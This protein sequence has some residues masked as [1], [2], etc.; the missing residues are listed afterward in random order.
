MLKKIL[1]G[2]LIG[3]GALTASASEI[4]INK[5]LD[6]LADN[7][8]FEARGEGIAGWEMV[9]RVTLNRVASSQFPDTISKVVHQ[10]KG[11][12]CQF[13]WYCDKNVQARIQKA[14]K[15]KIWKDI[16][17][18]VEGEYYEGSNDGKKGD[19]LFYHHKRLSQKKLGL[20][21]KVNHYATVGQHKFY[22]LESEGT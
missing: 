12:V 13:S 7:V 5:E 19:V 21:K 16:R 20:I 14:R 6:V 18:F 2:S 9:T 15:T 10:K 1:I 4:D 22:T 8:Y 11:N 17:E 3:L